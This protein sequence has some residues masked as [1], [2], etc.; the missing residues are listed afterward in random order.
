MKIWGSSVLVVAGLN[1]QNLMWALKSFWFC[2]FDCFGFC[3]CFLFLLFLGFLNLTQKTEPTNDL[4][5]FFFMLL[6]ID[7]SHLKLQCL[8][9]QC[10]QKNNVKKILC[11]ERV[12]WFRDLTSL[13]SVNRPAVP[14]AR[15]PSG[16]DRNYRAVS[17]TNPPQTADSY[18]NFTLVYCSSYFLWLIQSGS[19]LWIHTT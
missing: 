18:C 7:C 13:L 2:L 5:I 14:K 1:N 8:S 10:T 15:Y 12:W 16:W 6:Q 17:F 19:K 9:T 11:S 4:S 3:F